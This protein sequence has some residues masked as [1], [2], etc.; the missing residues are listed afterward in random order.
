MSSNILKTRF[1]RLHP[2]RLDSNIESKSSKNTYLN[3]V[4]ISNK[5]FKKMNIKE[6][7]NLVVTSTRKKDHFKFTGRIKS[8]TGKVSV[9]PTLTK[10]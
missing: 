5:L 8:V 2:L 7:Q 10:Q 3:I 4:E 6:M 1:Y 9:A